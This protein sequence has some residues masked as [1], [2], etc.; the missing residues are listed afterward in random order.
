MMIA[1][2]YHDVVEK[3][4]ARASGFA[5]ADADIYK[6]EI[7]LFEK[8]LKAVE[9][10]EIRPE[11]VTNLSNGENP[12]LL[13]TFDDGGKSAYTHIADALE[14]RGWRGH[15]F[16][17]TDFIDTPTFLSRSEIRELDTRGHLIGSHSASHP[18]RMSA[19]S[20]EQLREEW[21][22][23]TAK[24]ADILGKKI[25][26]ASVP[27]GHFSKQAAKAAQEKGIEILFNSEPVANFYNF[28]NCRIFGR[29]TIQQNTTA[30][31]AAAIAE[32]KLMPRLRQYLFW[33]A[34]KLAKKAGGE[35]YLDVREKILS[36][37]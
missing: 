10:A 21:H 22:K 15:F 8:H 31:A 26:I 3:G 37:R 25:K 6:L 36:K 16:V 30:M 1:L 4:A 14:S 33:N 29:Y 34:K 23:S 32:G 27:G 19:C 24:L 28:G 5:S 7:E 35:L 20:P 17:P 11:I 2:M 18:L 9:A 13:F 12:E